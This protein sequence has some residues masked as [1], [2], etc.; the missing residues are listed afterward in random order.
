[1]LGTMKLVGQLLITKMLSSKIIFQCAQELLSVKNEET[2]ETLATFLHAIGPAFDSPNW[3]RYAQLNQVFDTVNR[4][5]A[6]K[7]EVPSSRIRCLLKDVSDARAK[8]WSGK[9]KKNEPEGPMK[10]SDVAR[11]A[12]REEGG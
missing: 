4:L 8:G 3:A 6:S 5:A 2:L 10:I 9:S 12:K 7:K 1:M 11:Q